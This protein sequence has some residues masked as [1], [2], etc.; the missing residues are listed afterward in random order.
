[1]IS[2]RYRTRVK[3]IERPFNWNLFGE[4]SLCNYPEI[5]ITNTISWNINVIFHTK[6]VLI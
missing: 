4:I 2:S 5:V 1:M 6:N 3:V